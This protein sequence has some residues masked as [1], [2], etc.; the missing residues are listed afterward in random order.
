MIVK[1]EILKIG[2]VSGFVLSMLG[3]MVG[4][5]SQMSI[6]TEIDARVE[7]ACHNKVVERIPFGHQAMLTSS[8]REESPKLGIA[9]GRVDAKYTP[10]KWAPVSWTCRINPKNREVLRIEFTPVS[11]GHRIKS[12][13]SAFTR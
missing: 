2:I 8:Y 1:S 12:A 3:G 5:W 11:G 10:H 4:L 6:G 9:T 13:A 7:R